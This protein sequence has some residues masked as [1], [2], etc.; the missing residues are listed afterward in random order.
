MEKCAKE[1]KHWLEAQA[2][3]ERLREVQKIMN[4]RILSSM[5]NLI[6]PET[7]EEAGKVQEDLQTAEERLKTTQKAYDDCMARRD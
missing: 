1:R 3:V 4:G 5:N 6:T 2:E 7:L